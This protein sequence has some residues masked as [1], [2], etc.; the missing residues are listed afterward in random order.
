MIRESFARWHIPSEID[1]IV[2]LGTAS[3]G[4]G[5]SGTAERHRHAELELHF[6]THGRGTFLLGERRIDA[7]AGTLVWVPPRRDH[8]V[9]EPSA[10]FRRWMLLARPRLVRRVLPPGDARTLL[11]G[12][13]GPLAAALWRTLAAHQARALAAKFAETRSGDR[14]HWAVYNATVAYVLARS[15][16]AF[17]A[18]DALPSSSLLHPVVAEAV[19]VLREESGAVGRAELARRC[20][21]SES[22]LSRLFRAQVGV[23][24]V[25]FRNRCRLERFLELY[26]D[27]SRVKMAAAA[28]DAGFGSY[29]Q[30]HRVFRARMGYAPAEHARRL[31]VG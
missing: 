14:E 19:R 27:G 5:R 4:P 6:V 9:L 20:R 21:A 29:P 24:L 17:S 30:F 12:R 3:D 23:S 10:D 11:T 2:L 16:K 1:G 7:R 22:H 18:T 8:T 13:A 25:D 28:L 15:F 26:G 31:R